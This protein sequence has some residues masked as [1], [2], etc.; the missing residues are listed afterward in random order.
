M[1]TKNTWD[2]NLQETKSDLSTHCNQV[3]LLVEP[4]K[5]LKE[6]WT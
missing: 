6:N 4:F 2:L 3:F 1:T 5:F